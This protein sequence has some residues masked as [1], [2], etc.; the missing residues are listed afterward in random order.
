[1]VTKAIVDDI[2]TPY[3]IRVRIP[4]IDGAE[5]S[6]DGTL[7]E[8][9]GQS[10]ICSLPNS[11]NLVAVGDIVYVAFEDG[12]YAKPVII[13]HLL[14]EKGNIIYPD[15]QSR[16]LKVQSIAKLPQETTIGNVKP[17]DI[18]K[19]T[20]I[21]ANIQD[22]IDAIN[23]KLSSAGLL[24]TSWR[25]VDGNTYHYTHTSSGLSQI[26]LRNVIT[27]W[28]ENAQ[29][30]ILYHIDVYSDSNGFTDVYTDLVSNI[31]TSS[32]GLATSTNARS[33]G[34][35]ATI[36]LSRYLFI[37]NRYAVDQQNTNILAYRR[38]K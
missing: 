2:I 33:A 14:K 35:T 20:G 31:S 3:L 10:T 34:Y 18:Q 32:R 17:L 5:N 15:I 7:K 22:Q 19:L 25:F 26:D 11:S 36:L 4:L 12:D 9:L 37:S 29:Y 27:D 28:I 24:D 8:N 13:G 30:E 6:R 1:M 23:E 16:I 38:V 21:K